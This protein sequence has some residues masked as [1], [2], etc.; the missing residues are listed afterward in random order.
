MLNDSRDVGLLWADGVL[1][2]SPTLF[3]P[4]PFYSQGI[5]SVHNVIMLL[6]TE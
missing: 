1:P 3:L 4:V 5:L 2:A 6:L